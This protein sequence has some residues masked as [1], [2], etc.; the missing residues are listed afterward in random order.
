MV[1]WWPWTCKPPPGNCQLFWFLWEWESSM[2]SVR[3][4]KECRGVPQCF[5]GKDPGWKKKIKKRSSNQKFSPWPLDVGILL[6]YSG[7]VPL[8]GQDPGSLIGVPYHTCAVTKSGASPWGMEAGRPASSLPQ[9]LLGKSL[10]G[11]HLLLGVEVSLLGEA[12][13]G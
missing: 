3:Q 10:F 12:G 1:M 13:S 8:C 4:M 11:P 7:L 6:W 5:S 9:D 2:R